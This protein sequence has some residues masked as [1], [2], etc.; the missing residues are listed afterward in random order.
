MQVRPRKTLSPNFCLFW[1]SWSLVWNAVNSCHIWKGRKFIWEWFWGV[2]TENTGTKIQQSFRNHFCPNLAGATFL[3]EAT[4]YGSEKT[5]WPWRLVLIRFNSH[6]QVF[7]V[8]AFHE[9]WDLAAVANT[10]VDFDLIHLFHHLPSV[11]FLDWQV[12]ILTMMMNNQ[13][14]V[15]PLFFSWM[16][17]VG[18]GMGQSGQ[19]IAIQNLKW[20]QWTSFQNNRRHEITS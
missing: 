11:C 14:F 19:F 8:N 1:P 5:H 4:F 13:G 16:K 2:F 18:R 17:Q 12:M 20:N 6:S 7:N 10:L 3:G 15:H 9:D